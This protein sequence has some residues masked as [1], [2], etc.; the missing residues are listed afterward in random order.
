MIRPEK[1]ANQL[2]VREDGSQRHFRARASFSF[3]AP[4]SEL[5]CLDGEANES[6]LR[7]RNFIAIL[8]RRIDDFAVDDRI[9]NARGEN[10]LRRAVPQ[11]FR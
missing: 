8:L 6:L 9:L 1:G 3:L 5:P 7:A 2:V 11:V 4:E 10:P